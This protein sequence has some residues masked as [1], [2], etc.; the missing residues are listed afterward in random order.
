MPNLPGDKLPLFS[1]HIFIQIF[2][3]PCRSLFTDLLSLS[4]MESAP[5]EAVSVCDVK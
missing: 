2:I 4:I 5:C 1:L 3:R